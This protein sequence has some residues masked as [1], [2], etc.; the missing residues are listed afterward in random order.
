MRLV[1]LVALFVTMWT[2]IA[3]GQPVRD[4]SAGEGG[5]DRLPDY[6]FADDPG[7]VIYVGNG[8][9]AYTAAYG[10]ADIDNAIQ[11]V[12]EDFFRIGSVSKPFVAAAL[13]SLVEV[14]TLAL[15]DPI[16]DYLPADIVANLANAD[17]ATVRQMLQMTSGIPDYLDTDAFLDAV[18]TN[19]ATF[20]TPVQ[21][22]RFA[23]DEPAEFASG[24]GFYYSNSNYI[25][26]QIIIETLTGLSLAA[27]LDARV[28]GP[29]AIT[30]CYLET[31]ATFAANIVRGYD[32]SDD[33]SDD[34][35]D[36]TTIN[37]GVGLGDGGLVCTAA[38][39]AQF[40]P[41]LFATEIIGSAMLSAMLD[42]VPSDS[43][44]PY[45]LGIDV[46]PDGLYGLTVGHSGATSGFQ[47]VVI[48]LPDEELSVVALTNFAESDVLEDI[49]YDVQDWWF[50]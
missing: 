14:G 8:E 10:L 5:F 16:A 2:T 43:D 48:Y 7:V 29:A 20:W 49:V 4:V 47:A 31:E 42:S 26:A 44:V 12:A 39:L 46:D 40:L 23:Y 9:E 21:V 45:G 34:L 38:A 13:L 3:C 17:T 36:V 27:A 24:R 18:D 33:D 15:G 41:A 6:L 11:V 35:V 1:W 28:L 19:P 25:L 37:D 30:D 22:L 50:E 32:Y